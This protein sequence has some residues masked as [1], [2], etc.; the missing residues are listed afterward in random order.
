MVDIT[1]QNVPVVHADGAEHRRQIAVVLNQ[2]LLGRLNNTGSTTLATSAATTVVTDRK[3][4][5]SS[6]IFFTARTANAAAELASGNMYVS[7][8]TGESFTITHTNS[9]TTLR[10]FDYAIFG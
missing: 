9:A 8:V 6:R 2:V 10:T 4:A 3:V 1:R 5:A 7:A